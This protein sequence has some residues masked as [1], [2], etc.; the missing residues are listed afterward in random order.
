MQSTRGIL[1]GEADLSGD[2]R[3]NGLDINPKII[4]A[5]KRGELSP[6]LPSF[7]QKRS[8]EACERDRAFVQ[9]R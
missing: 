3:L 7:S 4:D 2:T 9:A 8:R 5:C 6:R 1:E